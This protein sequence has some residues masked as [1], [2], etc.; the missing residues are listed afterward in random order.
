MNIFTGFRNGFLFFYFGGEVTVGQN[1]M[2]VSLVN[3]WG[4]LK[5]I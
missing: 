3:F 2:G 1:W 4:L 5:F